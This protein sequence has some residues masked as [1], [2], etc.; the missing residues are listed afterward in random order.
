MKV[1]EFWRFTS[2]SS[3]IFGNV[4]EMLIQECIS[5]WTLQPPALKGGPCKWGALKFKLVQLPGRSTSAPQ[6]PTHSA[7]IAERMLWEA[8]VVRAEKWAGLPMT[9]RV[10]PSL[11][12][13]S[14]EPGL[15]LL[16]LCFVPPYTGLWPI[17]AE[18][19]STNCNRNWSW[20]WDKR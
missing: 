1:L 2:H 19:P 6:I 7:E 17:A 15:R 16:F 3:E 10:E 11:D 18:K 13:K 20:V 9:I 12:H 4:R 5:P 14:L 8:G